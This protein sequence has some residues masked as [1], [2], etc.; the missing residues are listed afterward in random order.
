MGFIPILSVNVSLIIDTILN[1]V[2]SADA[3]VN[4]DAQCEQIFHRMDGQVDVDSLIIFQFKI[5]YFSL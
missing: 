3:N 4:I 5:L 1:F 2:A